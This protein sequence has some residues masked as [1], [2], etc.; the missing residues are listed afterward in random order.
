MLPV[1][2]CCVHP[3]SKYL[4]TYLDNISQDHVNMLSGK[5]RMSEKLAR[6]TP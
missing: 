5:H 3:I 4:Y 2:S 1:E 6:F